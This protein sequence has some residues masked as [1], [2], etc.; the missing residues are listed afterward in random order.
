VIVTRT[1]GRCLQGC[2]QQVPR[3]RIARPTTAVVLP[4]GALLISGSWR[5]RKGGR[6]C[7]QHQCRCCGHRH[8]EPTQ[9]AHACLTFCAITMP[10]QPTGPRSTSAAGH[11]L[12]EKK[13]TPATSH[14]VRSF[15]PRRSH[16]VAP[17]RLAAQPHEVSCARQ[18]WSQGPASSGWWATVAV[19][20]SCTC[21]DDQ[22]RSGL[23]ISCRWCG[24]SPLKSHPGLPS[25]WPSYHARTAAWRI[26]PSAFTSPACIAPIALSVINFVARCGA[27]LVGAGAAAVAFRAGVPARILSAS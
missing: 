4:R 15:S 22:F 25:M 14:P 9:L 6:C 19:L 21:Q 27:E 3:P 7:S 16:D 5:L 1:R 11:T 17:Q 26:A 18:R 13:V 20:L 2:P 8:P 12:R 24:I 10:G 23:I